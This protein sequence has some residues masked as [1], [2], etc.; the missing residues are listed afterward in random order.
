MKHY[1]LSL[2]RHAYQVLRKHLLSDRRQEQMAITLCGI[3]RVVRGHAHELRLLVRDVILL[4]PDAFRQPE[5]GIPGTQ[6]RCPSLYPPTGLR[7]AT[8][9]GGLA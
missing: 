3:N 6:A 4:P 7:T 2:T 5:R 1:T 9:P 8:Y